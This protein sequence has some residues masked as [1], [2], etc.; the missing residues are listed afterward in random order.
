[1]TLHL[2]MSEQ[3]ENK[4]QQESDCSCIFDIKIILHLVSRH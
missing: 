3:M 2:E 4:T 1:V